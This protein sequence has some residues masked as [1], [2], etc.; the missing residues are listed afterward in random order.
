MASPAGLH[1]ANSRR[2]GQKGQATSA[3]KGKRDGSIE[4]GA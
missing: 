2:E 3:L 1:F 4:R